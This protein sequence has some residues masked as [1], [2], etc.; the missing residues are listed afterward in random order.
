MRVV[1]DENIDAGRRAFAAFGDVVPHPGREIDSEDVSRA[2]ALMVR[3]VTRVDRTLL[4]G[5]KV[6]FV[7]TATSG[8]DHLDDAYLAERGIRWA[9]APGCN[10][11]AVAD[12][13]L[14]SLAAL[15][16]RGRHDFS[17]GSAGIIGAGQAGSRVARRLEA[18]GYQVRLCD[19]P[20]AEAEGGDGFVGLDDALA[21]DVVSLHV[22]L[23]GDGPHPTRGLLGAAALGRL[24]A[25]AV[26]LNAAR[27]GVV[28][29]DALVRRVDDGP[30]LS[31]AVDTWAGEPAISA[32]L[33]ARADLGTPHVAGHSREG[34]L[35]GTAM[36]A[37]AAADHFDVALDW[38]A[39]AEL[40]PGPTLDPVD[41][42]VAAILSAY[43]PGDDDARLRTLL[44]LA[45]VERPR[46]FDGV[47][48]AC[49]RRRELGFHALPANAPARVAAAG[50][51]VPEPIDPGP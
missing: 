26:L 44:Q 3:S 16:R 7:G 20:R 51:G 19:P 17:R 46:A 25:G 13:V 29:E 32:D 39:H 38:D 50:F 34:R 35:R 28:D 47:R 11:A 31:V 23:T 27:G 14:A 24:P 12:W 5:A 1:I 22:P 33:L 43:D 49:Q 45:P 48:A 6:R 15:D 41:D 10:A 37:R 30:A 40:P 8:H 4:G 21:S 18:V 2:D 9:Y 42:P 36:I